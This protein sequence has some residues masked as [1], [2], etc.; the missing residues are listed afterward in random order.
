MKT[1][2]QFVRQGIKDPTELKDALQT[3]MRLEFSTIPPYL[4]AEWSIKLDADP[5]RVRNKIRGIVVQEMYHFAL[6]GNMLSA[7]GGTPGIAN[8]DF[9]P[10]YPTHLL[11]GD[12][13]QDLPVDLQPLSEG[14]LEVFMQIEKPEF[15]PVEIA[16]QLA[17]APAT[18]GEFYTAL[19]NAFHD[20]SPVIDQNAHAIELPPNVF[21]INSV[22]DARGAIDKIKGEGEGAPGNP[23]QPANPDQLAHYYV[24]KEISVGNELRFDPTT[25]KLV[26]VAGKQLRFPGIFP[27]APSTAIPSPS[28]TFN[29]LLKQ[30]LTDLEACWTTGAD[31]ADAA[32]LDMANLKAEGVKLISRGIRPEFVWPA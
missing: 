13:H 11:P 30:L 1:I 26:P 25:Q 5:D 21:R 22:D 31:F 20:L 4:C 27:F 9:L 24:F 18:I 2:T 29:A 17:V 16:A 15:P 28:T 3:A 10:K 32:L 8:P 7:I 6:A 14:Q 23:D 12:I 19:S